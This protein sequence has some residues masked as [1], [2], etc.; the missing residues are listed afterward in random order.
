[1]CSDMEMIKVLILIGGNEHC[2]LGK[3]STCAIQGPTFVLG[4]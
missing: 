1:M 4:H 2:I 3:L